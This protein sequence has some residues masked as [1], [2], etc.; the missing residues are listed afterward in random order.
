V[1]LTSSPGA[2]LLVVLTAAGIV[3][4]ATPLLLCGQVG[5]SLLPVSASH[6][7]VRRLLI[8]PMIH[9][10]LLMHNSQGRPSRCAVQPC[11]AL[12]DRMHAM[13]PA[14]AQQ[15]CTAVRR[16]ADVPRGAA[17]CRWQSAG[18]AA[19]YVKGLTTHRLERAGHCRG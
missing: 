17:H 7:P 16:V 18:Q 6:C 9:G 15:L 4:R 10:Q 11:V 3:V 5:V 14:A 13:L 1:V 12:A 2:C 8:A 19:V